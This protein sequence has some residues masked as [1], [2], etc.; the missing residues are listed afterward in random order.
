[1]RTIELEPLSKESFAPFG[2]VIAADVGG[3]IVVNEGT[4]LRIDRVLDIKNTRSDATLNVALFRSKPRAPG[5]FPLTMLEKHSFSA[6]LFVPMKGSRYAVAV[7]QGGDTPD[8]STLRAFLVRGDQGVSYGPGI[9]HHTLMTLDV[10]TDF[11]AFVWENGTPGDCTTVSL[12]GDLQVILPAP[13]S[14]SHHP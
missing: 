6:Q 4:A 9:W 5:P 12:S 1:M 7:A 8:L 10:Q 14:P 2:E 11:A 13:V 3:G